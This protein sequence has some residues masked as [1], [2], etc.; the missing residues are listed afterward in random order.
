MVNYR[1]VFFCAL[2]AMNLLYT[3]CAKNNKMEIYPLNV[4]YPINSRHPVEC[5]Q[6]YVVKN[7]SYTKECVDTTVQAIETLARIGA[8]HCTDYDIFVYLWRDNEIDT[9]I[10]FNDDNRIEWTSSELY[11]MHSNWYNG[12]L[13]GHSVFKK[14]KSF[15]WRRP[16]H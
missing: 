15:D 12:H 4:K 3:S 10:N 16:N 9:L 2:I 8:N 5:T 6:H 14:G 11:L 7:F 13:M 1:A